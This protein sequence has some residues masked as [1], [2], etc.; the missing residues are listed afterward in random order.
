MRTLLATARLTATTLILMLVAPAVPA[1]G[2]LYGGAGG[3]YTDFSGESNDSRLGYRI[4]G[5]YDF[6]RLPLLVNLGVEGGYTR[7]GSFS[8]NGGTERHGNGD[9]GLQATLTTLPLIHFHG[10]AG[11]E[12][13]DSEG[14]I[15]ALGGSIS[16]LPLAR[17]RAEYQNRNDFDAGMISLEVRTP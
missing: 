15:F 6:L 9:V 13:G 7:S 17:V 10:R 14:G 2:A 3:L 16:V 1:S 4:Y 8:D 11:Y 12:W 5:G